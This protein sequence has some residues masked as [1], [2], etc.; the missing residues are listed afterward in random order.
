MTALTTVLE[1]EGEDIQE[2]LAA[3]AEMR[4]ALPVYGSAIDATLCSVTDVDDDNARFLENLSIAGDSDILPVLGYELSAPPALAPPPHRLRIIARMDDDD[5]IE[6][7]VELSSGRQVLPTM[8]YL[9]ADPP[10]DEWS[11]STDVEVNGNTIGRVRARRLADGRTELAFLSAS[12]EAISP[13]IR[14]LPADMPEGVWL[15]TS[16]IQVPRAA[17][18]EGGG[19]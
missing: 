15:R 11:V 1:E 2:L 16:V 7:G 9:P 6:L 19:D 14:F 8:R 12:G 10:V 17:V 18:L 13:D 4:V 5:R 3:D